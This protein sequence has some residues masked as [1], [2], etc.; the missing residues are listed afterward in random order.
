MQTEAVEGDFCV[1]CHQNAVMKKL[2]WVVSVL[3]FYFA[4]GQGVFQING[5]VAAIPEKITHVVLN[6]PRG[7][8][9]KSDSARVNEGRYFF[10]GQTEEPVMAQLIVVYEPAAD[11]K[12]KALNMRRDIANVF[13]EPST[14]T[15]VSEDSFSNVKVSGSSAHAEYQVLKLLL[16]PITE[17]QESLNKEYRALYQKKDEEGLKKLEERFNE[18]EGQSQGIYRSYLQDNPGSPIVLYALKMFA[19]WDIDAEKVQPLFDQLPEK[20]R[21][22][23]SAIELNAKIDKARRTSVGQMAMDFTQG[24][25]LGNPVTLSSFRGKYVLIDFWAS[26]CG[27][28]RAENP[29]VVKAFE[30]YRDKG[31]HIIGVSLDQPN[32]REKWIKAIHDDRLTWTQVSDLQF[33]RNAVAVQYGI[34]AIPQNFLIDPQGKIIAKNLRGEELAAKLSTLF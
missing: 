27:P 34:Q 1:I 9:P 15:V 10:S 32:A 29:N 18:L 16:K 31:F 6:Y 23:P 11:G 3:G 2:L 30:Q 25:T 19:G 21:Q 28:C 17:Q 14:I 33:W 8:E 22:F 20:V 13:L 7:G 12:K 26:W 4:S 24:D 5:S